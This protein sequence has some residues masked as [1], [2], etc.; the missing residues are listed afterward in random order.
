MPSCSPKLPAR[1]FSGLSTPGSKQIFSDQ[2]LSQ[3]FGML[4]DFLNNKHEVSLDLTRIMLKEV[5]RRIDRVS[6]NYELGMLHRASADDCQL[7]GKLNLQMALKD[8]TACGL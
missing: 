8:T 3:C 6:K 5:R 2:I 4:K 1:G 7:Q